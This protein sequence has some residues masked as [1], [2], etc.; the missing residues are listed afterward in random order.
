MSEEG[1]TLGQ[2]RGKQSPEQQSSPYLSSLSITLV[3]GKLGNTI[4]LEHSS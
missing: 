2:L 3:D 1:Q 4:L